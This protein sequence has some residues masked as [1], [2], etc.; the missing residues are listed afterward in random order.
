MT[1]EP[2]NPEVPEISEKKQFIIDQY[3][4]AVK[5]T[6][7][8][9]TEV[10]FRDYDVT[11]DAVRHHFGSYP[12]LHDYMEENFGST[13][14]SFLTTEGRVFSERNL[15]QLSNDIKSFKRFIITT[16]VGGK[17]VHEGF[18]AAIKS[19]EKFNTA[20]LL[21]IPSEDAA[22][23]QSRN[24]WVFKNTFR[25]ETFITT[26]T[27]LNNSIFISN[28]R[29]S[30]KQIK[31]LTGVARLGQQNGS[32]IFASPKQF[33]EYVATSPASGRLPKAVMTTGAITVADY[34]N[35][36]YMS[37]RTSYIAENDHIIGA[38]IVEI[39]DDDIYHFR[40]IQANE[41]GSFVD[42]GIRYNPDGTTEA[43][44]PNIVLGDWHSGTVEEEMKFSLLNLARELMI[45]TVIVHDLFN[46]KA[47][48]P[49]EL[50]LPLKRAKIA[51]SSVPSLEYEIQEV[52]TDLNFL[53]H[54]FGNVVVV[55]SNHDEFLTRYI[56]GGLYM[57]DPINI[58]LASELVKPYMN[59]EDLLQYVVEN[60]SDLE[61]RDAI[62]WLNRES[63][64]KVGGVHLSQH[65]D[66]GSNGSKAS[67][68][69][70]EKDVSKAVVG[71]VHSGAIMRGIFRVGIAGSL[72]QGY[73]RNGGSSNW[74]QTHCLVYQDGSRQL[75]NFIDGE[76]RLKP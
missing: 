19:Y 75:I 15:D 67:M 63:E 46:G 56:E 10:S 45:D 36:F 68:E 50:M 49:H 2:Q 54:V 42:Y 31:P 74:T 47:I 17:A 38:V 4:V 3:L 29:V 57:K 13:I 41:E 44:I 52:G 27:A 43:E 11:R 34:G 18:L 64:Y 53:D 22:N 37:Q 14:D 1:D 76:Y 33:L 59:D 66:K 51:A 24:K 55:K 48:N 20:K 40:Q 60:Y 26:E 21:L 30:A 12:K 5:A 7:A 32:N 9:P 25:D 35:D 62:V 23:S 8:L 72:D 70:I 69:S 71:H 73:N 28:L 61:D 16:A 39:K 58:P 6:E 65:G